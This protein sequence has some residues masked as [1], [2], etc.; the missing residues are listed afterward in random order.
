MSSL[1]SQNYSVGRP[2]AR[3]AA[4]GVELTPGT[5]YVAALVER[6]GEEGFDRLDYTLDAWNEGHR[7]PRLFGFWRSVVPEQGEEH[8][9]I[10][11][12]EA[13]L[14]LFEQLGDSDDA[15]R[16]A[17]RYV[18]ALMLV[19]KRLIR[20]ESTRRVDGVANLVIRLRG[21]SGW[22]EDSRV[23]EVV[24]PGLDQETIL[25]VTEQL[26]QVLRGEE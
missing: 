19:R 4:T 1:T 21:P 12:D 5:R 6:D 25:S 3:C 7:P 17:F 9:P 16:L 22:G 15:K 14:S 13:L 26:G 2:S 20:H 10:V 8:K 11:D 18:L 23:E 24:D